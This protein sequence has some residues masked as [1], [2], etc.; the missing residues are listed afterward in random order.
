[1]S[2]YVNTITLALM[3]VFVYFGV[4][5]IQPLRSSLGFEFYLLLGLVAAGSN[6]I[7][8]G[9][10]RAAIMAKQQLTGVPA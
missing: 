8:G 7:A 4:S 1:M 2:K 5:W 6:V 10:V 3:G 9:L